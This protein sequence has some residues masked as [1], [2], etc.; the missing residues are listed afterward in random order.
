MNLWTMQSGSISKFKPSLKELRKALWASRTKHNGSFHGDY[1][2]FLLLRS[3]NQTRERNPRK[4]KSTT[5]NPPIRLSQIRF[6][7]RRFIFVSGAALREAENLQLWA[8]YETKPA[9]IKTGCGGIK[10]RFCDFQKTPTL[11]NSFFHFLNSRFFAL[12]A[13]SSM[14]CGVMVLVSSAQTAYRDG[15]GPR[16]PTSF[17]T[18]RAFFQ[19]SNLSVQ[20]SSPFSRRAHLPFS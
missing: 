20:F 5:T 11:K 4:Q 15:E 10:I 6:I 16:M 1:F 19:N 14:H 13:P 17:S 2:F 12:T 3:S 7:V 18:K 8:S 9:A